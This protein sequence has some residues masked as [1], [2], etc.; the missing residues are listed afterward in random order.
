MILE[1]IFI[2]SIMTNFKP[3]DIDI[4]DTLIVLFLLGIFCFFGF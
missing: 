2:H 4:I 3:I 1:E